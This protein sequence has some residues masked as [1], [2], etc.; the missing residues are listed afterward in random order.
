[1]R[2]APRHRLAVLALALFVASPVFAKGKLD[3][4]YDPAA[5]APLAGM[6]V[7][8]Y[9]ED[10][11]LGLQIPIYTGKSGERMNIAAYRIGSLD[12]GREWMWGNSL[13]IMTKPD[14]YIALARELLEPPYAVL[15]DGQCVRPM[16]DLFAQAVEAGVR[17]SAWGGAAKVERRTTPS[18]PAMGPRYEFTVAYS[19]TPDL[20]SLVTVVTARAFSDKLP[21]AGSKWQERAAWVDELIIA[22]DRLMPG[23][24]SEQDKARAVAI[25]NARYAALGMPAL[26][27]QANAGDSEARRKALVA[28][29]DHERAL[30]K[31]TSDDEWPLPQ[32]A[33][34]RSRMW[35]EGD[36]ARLQ[37]AAQANAAE[38]TRLVGE[39]LAHGLPESLPI[40]WRVAKGAMFG[41]AYPPRN[42]A[43]DPAEALQR[44]LYWD[45]EHKAFVSRRAGDNVMLDFRNGRLP[46]E[47]KA[48][49][50]PPEDAAPDGPP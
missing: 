36:C 33:F 31:A 8:V 28:K 9:V 30:R 43:E 42:L 35:A 26:I 4:D 2:I 32:A 16:G 27:A 17:T 47:S 34:R 50:L 49:V 24:K 21:G 38:A 44:R 22:S 1:M 29:E 19:L 10:P 12:W 3:S 37:A 13:G 25:E 48:Y 11:V 5:A 23:A 46:D 18:E 20:S 14:K 6:P 41:S 40:D 45:R 7:I 15:R 39:M